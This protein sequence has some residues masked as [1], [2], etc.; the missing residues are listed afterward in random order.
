MTFKE[1]I[2]DELAKFQGITLHM[3]NS[4]DN[5]E[6]EKELNE[7]TEI[8]YKLYEGFNKWLKTAELDITKTP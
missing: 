5:L 6:F 1:K 8:I 7:A 4:K 3:W 2:K